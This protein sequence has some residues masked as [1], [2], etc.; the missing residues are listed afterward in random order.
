M[1]YSIVHRIMSCDVVDTSKTGEQ[2]RYL[3][4]FDTQNDAEMYVLLLEK[5]DRLQEEFDE[6]AKYMNQCV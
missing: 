6:Y 1:R 4:A 5:Y 2:E 3:G